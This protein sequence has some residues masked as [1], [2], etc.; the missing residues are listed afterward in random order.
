M[1]KLDLPKVVRLL[2]TLLETLSGTA[3]R[4]RG[5]VRVA[6]HAFEEVLQAQS[7]GQKSSLGIASNY[8]LDFLL[9]VAR[10]LNLAPRSLFFGLLEQD[11]GEV[12]RAG[13]RPFEFDGEALRDRS[14][15]KE[16]SRRA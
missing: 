1:R 10:G 11:N 13:G 6:D 3:P 9:K 7:E 12:D 8:F 2:G 5:I 15:S 14:K 16:L 4:T